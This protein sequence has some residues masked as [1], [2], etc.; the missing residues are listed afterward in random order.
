LPRRLESRDAPAGLT[1]RHVKVASGGAPRVSAAF[2]TPVAIS[3][4]VLADGD[5]LL[6]VLRWGYAAIALARRPA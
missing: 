5:T 1:L 6:R 2:R 4:E 3:T